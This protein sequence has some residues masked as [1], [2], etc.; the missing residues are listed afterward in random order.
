M[1]PIQWFKDAFAMIS[2]LRAEAPGIGRWGAMLNIPMT[3]G[4]LVFIQRPEGSLPLVLNTIAVLI[5]GQIHKRRRFSRLTSLCH[6]MWI[7]ALPVLITG[8]LRADE[9]LLL[10]AWLLYTVATMAISLVLDVRN[11]VLYWLTSDGEFERRESA[12]GGV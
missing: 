12:D 11:L 3:I 6:V 1:N 2:D 8:L 9:S 5:A 7:P 4:G 10:R